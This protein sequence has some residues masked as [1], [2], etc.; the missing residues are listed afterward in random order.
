VS[1]ESRPLRVTEAGELIEL[2]SPGVGIFRSSVAEDQLI[3]SGQLLGSLETLGLSR[4][5]RVPEGVT[6]R[7]RECVG[8][9]RTRVPV[10]HGEVLVSLSAADVARPSTEEVSA[11]P[12]SAAISF[13]AP[14]SG[15]F[16]GRPSPD[17]APFVVPGDT[18][19]RGQTI[20]LLEVMKT[21]NRLVYQGE[22]LPETARVVAVVPTDGDDVSR[23][24]PILRLDS[25]AEE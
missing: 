22:S 21:F 8:G 19:K 4:E 20:G 14:M 16:Y 11:K 6:G 18:V 17:E 24:D 2:R 25:E 13:R 5:L 10:E 12:D 7:V 9:H 23:G 15:R 1:D 3:S